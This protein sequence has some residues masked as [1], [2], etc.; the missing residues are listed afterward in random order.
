MHCLSLCFDVQ[1]I[2]AA[3]R[4]QRESADKAGALAA[5]QEAAAESQAEA[6]KVGHMLQ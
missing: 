6:D 3:A 5:A 4:A 1:A 2:T